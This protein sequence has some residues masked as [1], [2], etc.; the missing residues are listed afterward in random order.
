LR[1]SGGGIEGPWGDLAIMT[2]SGYAVGV[3]LIDL[4]THLGMFQGC[5]KGLPSKVDQ[6]GWAAK[7]NCKHEGG[8]MEQAYLEDSY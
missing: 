7:Q 2:R 6:M 4:N 3:V 1:L 5:E 8:K